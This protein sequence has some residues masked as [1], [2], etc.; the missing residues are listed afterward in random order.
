MSWVRNV[1]LR[2]STATGPGGTGTTQSQTCKGPNWGLSVRQG[3]KQRSSLGQLVPFTHKKSSSLAKQ[4]TGYSSWGTAN[5][6]RVSLQRCCPEAAV[7]LT[8][9]PLN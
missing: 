1:G 3:G 8:F 4:H 2:A 9:E 5:L 7:F 6:P